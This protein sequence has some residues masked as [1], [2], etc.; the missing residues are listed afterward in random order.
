MRGLE[1]LTGILLIGL[2]LLVFLL[3]RPEWAGVFQARW[4][5]APFALPHRREWQ[6]ML[7]G[8][9][10][11]ITGVGYGL[12]LYPYFVGSSAPRPSPT[13]PVVAQAPLS[14]PAPFP[15]PSPIPPRSPE[16][17]PPAPTLAAPPSP[18][19]VSPTPSSLAC[20][21]EV[22]QV[23]ERANAAQEA[24]IQGQGTL[25]QLTAAWGDAAPE[26]RRQGD[27]LRQAAQAI[28]AT[29]QEIRWEIHS[30][31]PVSQPGPDLLEVRTEETWI[32]RARMTCPPG[33]N[34]TVDRV[35]TYPGEIYRLAAQGSTWRILRW[36]PGEGTIR[37]DWRCP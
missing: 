14:S 18:I 13:M 4:G 2:G 8:L 32:Y 23:I 17:S 37:Q 15:S 26:A 33:Q 28:R 1:Q 5:K 6:A 31:A 10:F 25:E 22:L 21:P 27:R 34:T 7:T 20:E 16:S 3:T 19:P 11:L 36:S 24:Y 30:C 9:S 29:I 35:V 12:L